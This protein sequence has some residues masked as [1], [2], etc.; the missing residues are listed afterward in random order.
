QSF[1]QAKLDIQKIIVLETQEGNALSTQ[2]GTSIGG[3]IGSII[4]ANNDFSNIEKLAI[5]TSTTVVGQNVGE[6]LFWKQNGESGA[7]DDI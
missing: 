7:F 3:S 2:L 4:I 5:S 1:S 6:Y